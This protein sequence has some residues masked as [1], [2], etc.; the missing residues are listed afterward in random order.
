MVSIDICTR[1]GE[2][3]DKVLESMIERYLNLVAILATHSD[4]WDLYLSLN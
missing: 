3:V 1:Y 4:Q 2:P